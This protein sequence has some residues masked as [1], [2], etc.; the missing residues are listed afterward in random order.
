VGE[1]ER[2][3]DAPRTTKALETNRNGME[4]GRA[5]LQSEVQLSDIDKKSAKRSQ[6]LE[7][8]RNC[9][10]QKDLAIKLKKDNNKA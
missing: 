1:P 8:D 9:Q 2:E 5:M 6:I 10:M 4:T 7:S 3:E